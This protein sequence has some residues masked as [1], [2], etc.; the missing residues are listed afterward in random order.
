M[1][2]PAEGGTMTKAVCPRMDSTS[3]GSGSTFWGGTDGFVSS[4]RM[5]EPIITN[6]TQTPRLHRSVVIIV[7]SSS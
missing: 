3:P 7:I 1:I 6:K 2:F 4:A 5:D